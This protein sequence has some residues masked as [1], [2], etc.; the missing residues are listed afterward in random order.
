MASLN[1]PQQQQFAIR[2]RLAEEADVTR[3]KVI[4][5]GILDEMEFEKDF[6]VCCPVCSALFK[7]EI[8]RLGVR[9]WREIAAQLLGRRAP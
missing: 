7:P 6:D 2:D 5:N 1:T 8:P 9:K 3:A 4:L